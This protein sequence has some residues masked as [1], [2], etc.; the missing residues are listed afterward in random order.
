MMPI[1]QFSGHIELSKGMSKKLRALSSGSDA[2]MFKELAKSIETNR[3]AIADLPDCITLH[4]KDEKTVTFQLS[5][6]IA[7][8]LPEA[9]LAHKEPAATAETA[10]VIDEANIKRGL[11][12]L[13]PQRKLVFKTGKHQ[14]PW[15]NL[16]IAGFVADRFF[17]EDVTGSS[18]SVVASAIGQ[19]KSNWKAAIG[20]WQKGLA[21]SPWV[22]ASVFKRHNAA[23]FNDI[24]DAFLHENVQAALKKLPGVGF[25]YSSHAPK[26]GPGR[27]EVSERY[28][29]AQERR[30]YYRKQDLIPRDRITISI[31]L[32]NGK[33]HAVELER[34][35]EHD[36]GERVEGSY[37][38]IKG[39]YHSQRYGETPAQFIQRG[40]EQAGN[41]KQLSDDE[42]R[43]LESISTK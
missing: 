33:S 25:T 28:Y 38:E 6:K 22:D 35:I 32:A 14:T 24:A 41:L 21:I 3:Q 10:A 20:N 43:L 18:G 19:A 34:K 13:K 1:L 9:V 36:R 31:R 5:D 12:S 29:G 40:L 2:A 42:F 39:Y 4:V 26:K 7:S 27:M 16:N 30:A 23:E 11:Q 15:G 8:E 17:Q 37:G